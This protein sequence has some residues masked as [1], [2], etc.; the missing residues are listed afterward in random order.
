MVHPYQGQ[1]K[2]K[3]KK[4]EKIAKTMQQININKVILNVWLLLSR[5]TEPV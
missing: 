2:K 4:K 5:E 1:E 3:E